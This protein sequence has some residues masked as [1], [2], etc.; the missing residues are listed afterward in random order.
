MSKPIYA[1]TYQNRGRGRWKAVFIFIVLLHLAGLGVYLFFSNADKQKNTEATDATQPGAPAPAAPAGLAPLAPARPMP[2]PETRAL[3]SD[4]RS[5]MDAGQLV[6]AKNMLD[7]AAAANPTPEAIELLGDINMQLLKSPIMIPGK[8][9]YVIQ[10][11]D[12]LQ[13]IAKKYRTTVS[14]LKEM[15]GLKTDT[16]QAGARLLAFNGDITIR[17]SKTRNE[18][19]LISGGKLF[20][21]YSVGTGK[22]GKTPAV[23]FNIVDKIIE[24]PW[25]RPS[26]NKQVEYGDPENVL[27]TRWMKIVSTDHPEITGFGIHGTWQRDSIG[28]Q[29]SA[30]C[31]RML[32]E[33]VEELFDLVP[34]KTTV[35]I[36]E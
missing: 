29:S 15:N 32:N 26:D 1:G 16:I 24:P 8:E 5:A 6:D 33:D 18:L 22:F 13:K 2:S 20:K 25:T 21:R 17:V 30:G 19:D 9:Y 3:I 7:R 14:L 4:A 10:P 27:G 28:Q 35:I 31:I 36:T 34:R 23:E 12:Y 11:G